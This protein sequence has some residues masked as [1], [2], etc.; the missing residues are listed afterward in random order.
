MGERVLVKAVSGN[1]AGKFVL[2]PKVQKQQQGIRGP[3]LRNDGGG[4]T[5]QVT[6]EFGSNF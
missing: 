2:R 5:G 3:E 6:K 1:H 4:G